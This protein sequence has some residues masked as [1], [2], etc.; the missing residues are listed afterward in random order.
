M[1]FKIKLQ[2]YNYLEISTYKML[3]H[4]QTHLQFIFKQKKKIGIH[5]NISHLSTGATKKFG[6]VFIIQQN[7]GC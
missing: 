2:D 5:I 3:I 6:S 4:F 1:E 7:F